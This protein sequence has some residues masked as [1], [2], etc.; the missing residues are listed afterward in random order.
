MNPSSNDACMQTLDVKI[1]IYYIHSSMHFLLIGP[2]RRGKQ[3]IQYVLKRSRW[4][5]FT[6]QTSSTYINVC[7]FWIKSHFHSLERRGWV[8]LAGAEWRR[9][10]EG[11]VRTSCERWTTNS[12][13]P[14]SV[15]RALSDPLSVYPSIFLFLFPSASLC[16]HP[17]WRL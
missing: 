15:F 5:V 8:A 12:C 2:F 1:Y 11:R 17:R 7:C 6:R 13:H 14:D 16:L 4:W 10:A 3:P 9:A